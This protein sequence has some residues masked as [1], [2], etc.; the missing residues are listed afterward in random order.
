[1]KVQGFDERLGNQSGMLGSGLYFADMASKADQY[2]GKYGGPDDTT[3]GEEAAMFLVRVSLGCPYLTQKSLEQMRR[4]PC[5]KGHFD[6]NLAWIDKKMHGK[7]WS[8]KG[9][10]LEMCDDRRLDSVISDRT[11]DEGHKLY[12]EYAVYGR[13]CYPEFCVTYVREEGDAPPVRSVPAGS[14]PG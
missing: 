6:A 8:E 12:H 5:T 4:P 3:V 1:M 7:P 11:I 14:R 2:A 13:Q 10:P 9:L